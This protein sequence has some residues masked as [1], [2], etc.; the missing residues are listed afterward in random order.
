[1]AAPTFQ[2]VSALFA[3]ANGTA[4]GTPTLP[5]HAADDC[6]IM[7][8][9]RRS[10]TNT[11]LTPAGWTLLAGPWN[12][13]AERHYLFGRRATSGAE[14]NP[15]LDWSATAG[16]FFALIANYRGCRLTSTP[17]D[18]IGATSVGTAS[19]ITA[20]GIT[21]NN[22]NDL[23]VVYQGYGDDNN[24]AATFATTGT[25]PAAYA[26]HFAS[27]TTGADG[28]IQIAEGAR[29]T[30]GATGTISTAAVTITAGDGWGSV[31]LSLVGATAATTSLPY[32]RDVMQSAL[33]LR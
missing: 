19:P 7:G 9:H 11:L 24:L 10:L 2:S 3:L 15:L 6:F 12:S 13:V 28:T 23:V 21:T 1:M 31:A 20:S 22:A 17:W 16:D 4:D 33:L 25:D 26:E 5:A 14:T 8:V 30:A 32:S 27:S 29:V 18:V